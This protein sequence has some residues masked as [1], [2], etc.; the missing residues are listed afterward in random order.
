LNE[1]DRTLRW[2]EQ[3]VG[4]AEVYV[5]EVDGDVVG[6]ITGGP[7]R[8]PIEGYDAELYAIYL[9]QSAQGR[10]IGRSLLK[11]LSGSLLRKG[12]TGM[13]VWVLEKNPS[14]HFYEKSN[15]QLVTSASKNIQ[16]GGMTLTEVAYGW[17][18]LAAIQLPK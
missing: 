13:I 7:I 11:A 8:E 6:F 16:I 5:A 9:L 12:L 14:K 2:R 10:G 18:N 4:D 15:A 17:R 1:A 3:L